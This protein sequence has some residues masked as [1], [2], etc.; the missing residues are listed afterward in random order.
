MSTDPARS[1][2]F[3]IQ[4]VRTSGVAMVVI[5]LLVSDGAIPL[6]AVA[7]HVLIAIGLVDTFLIPAVLARKWSSRE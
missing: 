5:G 4:A 3:A 1:R 2:F 7:G 6:P